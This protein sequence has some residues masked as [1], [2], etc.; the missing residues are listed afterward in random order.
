VKRGEEKGEERERWEKERVQARSAEQFAATS[1]INA[2][3]IHVDE[4]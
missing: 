1:E 4:D 3:S 2:L